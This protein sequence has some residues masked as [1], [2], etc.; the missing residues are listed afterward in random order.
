MDGLIL[1]KPVQTDLPCVS[2]HQL[3]S[4]NCWA[5]RKFD[6]AEGEAPCNAQMGSNDREAGTGWAVIA[7]LLSAHVCPALIP[8]W[9]LFV[10]R[11]LSGS[12]SITVFSDSVISA[13]PWRENSVV[14][15]T[16]L[17]PPR[18]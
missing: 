14:S 12:H 9:V 17:P 15:G 13:R 18:H 10:S 1:E 11:P 8:G 16:G 2:Q 5:P 4:P 6:L 3:L 7:F